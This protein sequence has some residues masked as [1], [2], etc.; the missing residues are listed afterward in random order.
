MDRL[1]DRMCKKHDRILEFFCKTEQVCV[2]QCCTEFDH[3]SHPVVPLKAEYEVKMAQLGK[4]EAEVP[5][6]IQERKLKI[7]EIKDTVELSNEEA[8][9]EIADARQAL[10]ALIDCVEKCLDDFKN[11]RD[12]LDHFEVRPTR[13]YSIFTVVYDWGVALQKYYIDPT[14]MSV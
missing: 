14:K 3:R 1:E 8:D 9:E 4:M 7:K 11:L 12:L 2:C 10:T 5:Q 6:M 13:S